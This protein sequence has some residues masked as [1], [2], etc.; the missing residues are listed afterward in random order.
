MQL[1]IVQPNW[2]SKIEVWCF[3]REFLFH[4][5]RSS[6]HQS[7]N[8]YSFNSFIK[9][10]SQR[11]HRASRQSAR[12]K[13]KWWTSNNSKILPHI[14]KKKRARWRPQKKTHTIHNRFSIV[15]CDYCGSIL[16]RPFILFRFF[17]KSSFCLRF[18][19]FNA[20]GAPYNVEPGRT[21]SY[22][23]DGIHIIH[24]NVSQMC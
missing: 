19:S 3:Y 23:K 20:I 13:C 2:C 21:L 1:L 10:K 12:D 22:A 11:A 24:F 9:D 17:F 7:A 6:T 8:M 18:V 15:W 4:G 5:M 16:L 14:A